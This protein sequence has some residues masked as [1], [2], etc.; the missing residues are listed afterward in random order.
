MI[1]VYV[2][3]L[4]L[5]TL[6]PLVLF[7]WRAAAQR[8][9][10][11]AAL[12]LHRAQLL[13]LDRDL[14]DGRLV[15][16]EHAG[17]VL[18]VQRRLLAD[19]SLVEADGRMSGPLPVALTALI[20]PAA[21]IALYLAGGFPNFPPKDGDSGQTASQQQA[22]VAPDPDQEAR[23]DML[24]AQ[25]RARLA[26]MDVGSDK[27]VEGYTILGKA[28]YSRH[29][30]QAAVDA[31]KVVMKNHF[32]PGLAADIGEVLTQAAGYITPEALTYFKRS[33]AESAPDAPWMKLVV[34]R[35]KEAAR[36]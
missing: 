30:Y 6:A 12:A 4:V 31:W 13:E 9:R 20:V 19:A 3:A 2:A 21:A 32:D 35:L 22:A 18:E 8:G 23:D 15:P 5:I 17:A 29:R 11:E 25:L 26:L 24:I 36:G 10:Q 34:K 7:A 14:A 28:E 1:W 16:E 27:W 33:A